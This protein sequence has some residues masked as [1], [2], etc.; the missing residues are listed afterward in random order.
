MRK[1]VKQSLA[2]RCDTC[3]LNPMNILTILANYA[4]DHQTDLLAGQVAAM[5]KLNDNKMH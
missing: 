2:F 1:V 4:R 5:A 3:S